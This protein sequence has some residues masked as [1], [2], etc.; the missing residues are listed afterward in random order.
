MIILFLGP[1]GAGKGTQC[2]FLADRYR[3][4]HLSS[5]DILRRERQEGTDL[6]KQA[7]SYMDSGRLVPD[8]LIVAMMRQEIGAAA[9]GETSGVILDGFPRTLQ[10]AQALDQALRDDDKQVDVVLNLDVDDD[11]LERRITG[12]RS[13]PRC[14][15]AYHV[16]FNP[17]RRANVCDR[18]GA[19]LAQR[20]DDTAAVVRKRIETYHQQTAPLIDYYGH[21]GTLQTVDGNVPIEQV[22][23]SLSAILDGCNR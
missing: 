1:P 13:C 16:D 6:G 4:R 15:T 14:G 18:D 12:R 8:D 23:R 3:L 17:P 10:Q 9:D 2:K 7:Q 21:Q 20:S 22:T 5:G 11:K 19:A